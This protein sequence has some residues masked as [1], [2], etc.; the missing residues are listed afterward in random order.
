MTGWISKN[1]YRLFAL[2]KHCITKCFL[3]HRLVAQAFI[4]NPQKMRCINHKNEDKTDNRVENLEWCSHY[5]NNH[6]GTAETKNYKP[7][8][9]TPKNG[10]GKL[11]FD[12]I[13]S[14]AKYVHT[15]PSNIGSCCKGKRKTAGGYKWEY[16]ST[17]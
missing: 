6:Y 4:Q 17:K 3:G 2:T 7:V 15:T 13:K 10:V 16:A 5:E 14:A 8:M 11:M 1:G 9:G 12:S